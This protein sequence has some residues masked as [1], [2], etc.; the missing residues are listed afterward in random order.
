M[1]KCLPGCRW[2]QTMK[3]W[4]IP[5]RKDYNQYLDT[6]FNKPIQEKVGDEGKKGS[7]HQGEI[8]V[9]GNYM[10]IYYDTMKLRRLSITTQQ[11]YGE[12][13]GEFVSRHENQNIDDLNFSQLYYYIKDRAQTLGF[14]RRRQ[15]IAAIKFY[16]EKVLVRDKMFFNLGKQVKTV[17][18]PV[19]LSF[20][21]IKSIA[22]RVK[23]PH[24]KLILFLA[25][26]LNL[27][28]KEIASLKTNDNEHL[29]IDTR[30]NGNLTVK[31]YLEELWVAHVDNLHPAEYLFE[32]KG[33]P[34][35][36]ANLRKRVYKL[37]QY[38]QLEEIYREQVQNA[39][40]ENELSIPT[41]KAY[42]SMFLYFVKSFGF[43][44]PSEISNEEIK[45]FLL[46]TGQKSAAYQNNV[47]SALKFCYKAIFNRNINERY[48]VRPQKG[49]RL[50]DVLDRDEIVAI[51]Q[52]LDNL[53]H[54]LLITLIYSAGL[55]RSEAQNLQLRDIHIK[56]G[57]LFIRDSKGNKDR[58]TVLSGRLTGLLNEYLERYEPSKYLFE[59][60]NPGEKYSFTSMSL[61]LK[62]AAKSAGIHRRVH[63]H[64]LRHSFAT[65]CLE[66]GMDIRYVQELLGHFSLKTTER[67][68]HIT[69]VA[70]NNLKSP[71]DHL[72]I[73]KNGPIFK[74]GLS[75]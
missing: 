17:T 19:C 41:K 42:L 51:Y 66:E 15:M 43:K 7:A 63:L 50:P 33:K 11:A 39:L 28:P 69:T 35:E 64:M 34:F 32:V 16:Y 62:S 61:V 56:T 20:Y 27:S 6:Y 26:Y 29:K 75:P 65:H 40:D 10:K 49:N 25:Y 22:S 72:D 53:K 47:I 3:A 13:F 48:L 55:R 52:Q 31:K 12:F 70:M 5:Y 24:D 58:I 73:E 18:M 1:V 4:H 71:F 38:Y 57:Q 45:E 68:T 14:T 21:K 30:L 54:K 60:D 8:V 44:H 46:L 74:S 59:G 2:S 23:S 37:L 67:Y 36:A 9:P